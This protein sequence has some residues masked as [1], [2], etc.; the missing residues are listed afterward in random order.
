MIRR[1][2]EIATRGFTSKRVSDVRASERSRDALM[3]ERVQEARPQSGFTFIETLI[4]VALLAL[5]T[6][7]MV[8]LYLGY[9]VIFSSEQAVFT[10]GSR[11]H[12]ATSAIESATRQAS[13]VLASHTVSG[14]AYTTDA[15]TLVLELPSA[16]ASGTP[17]A[18][19]FDYVIFYT[20]GSTLYRLVEADGSSFRQSGTREL[21]DALSAFSFVYDTGDV[22]AATSVTVDLTLSTEVNHRT[23]Q[24]H[25]REEAYL[26]NK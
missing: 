13:R 7:A 5:L 6:L 14:T 25:L 18:N 12:D 15:D 3:S 24:F 21:T 16:D 17:L 1:L 20:S 8:Q 4:A 19:D 22:T 9:G 23:L 11:A 26:R 10:L 2:A